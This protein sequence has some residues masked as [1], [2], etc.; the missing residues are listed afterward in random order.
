MALEV[1]ECFDRIFEEKY[2]PVL[3]N[4]CFMLRRGEI[5]ELNISAMNLMDNISWMEI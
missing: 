2:N 5:S 3:I 4:I 1:S